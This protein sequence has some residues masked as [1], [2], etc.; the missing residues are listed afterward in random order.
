MGSDRSTG[1]TRLNP[2]CDLTGCSPI[3]GHKSL[4]L[5]CSISLYISYVPPIFF[6]LLRRLGIGGAPPP[7]GHWNLGRWGLPI[8]VVAICY[9]AMLSVWL[10]FPAFL[11]VQ[12]ENMNYASVIWIGVM[13]F[14]LGAYFVSGGKRL[15]LQDEIGHADKVEEEAL[16]DA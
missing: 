13:C 11:P 5:L 1:D 6:L 14:A 7:K 12:K 15:R 9:S 16:K 10:S 4:F 8:N 3:S 2:D